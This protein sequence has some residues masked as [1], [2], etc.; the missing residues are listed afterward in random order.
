MQAA[1]AGSPGEAERA[2]EAICQR[3]W[4]PIYAF[5]R[6]GGRSA[7]DAEDLTQMFFE[8][9]ITED[10]LQAAR[11][12]QGRLRS[13]LLGVLKRV[14]ADH[15]R[16]ESAEKRGGGRVI[17]SFDEMEAEERYAREPQ[18]VRDPEWL[19]TRA[20]AHELLGSV[21][22]K[23]RTAFET[24][25]RAGIFDLLL[26]YLMLDDEPPSY[27][28]IAGKLGSSEGAT[29][30]LIHRLREKFRDLLREEVAGTVLTPEEVPGELA[31][32]RGVL[33]GA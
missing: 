4:Y 29:G 24:T 25:G 17:V 23:M 9:L 10:A 16:R 32:L 30:V 22:E 20:W 27:R 5:L 13:Y 21:R 15:A 12:D 11:Q 1:Q 2:L 33:G 28:E 8:R 18:D 6:R 26:P 14:L 19:Y 31:W 7:H 3:Y